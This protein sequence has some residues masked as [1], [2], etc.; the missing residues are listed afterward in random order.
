MLRSSRPLGLALGAGLLLGSLAIPGSAHADDPTTGTT[1]TAAQV[2]ADLK[3]VVAASADATAKGYS[4]HIDDAAKH[5]RRFRADVTYDAVHGRGLIEENGTYARLLIQHRGVYQPIGRSRLG[6]RWGRKAAE[7]INRPRAIWLFKPDSTTDL[8][9]GHP[10]LTQ[11]AP[12]AT[13]ASIVRG[14]YFT[15]RDGATQS[16]ADDGVTTYTVEATESVSDTQTPSSETFTI[17]VAADGTLSAVTE[18]D[19]SGNYAVTYG[20]GLQHVDVPAARTVLT[21]H[22]IVVGYVLA[23]MPIE[24]RG[25]ASN[26][27][28]LVGHDPITGASRRIDLGEL[29][30][31]V[32]HEVQGADHRNPA[33]R[34]YSTRNVARGIAITGTNRY[35]HEKFVITIVLRHGQATIHRS[36]PASG[37]EIGGIANGRSAGLANGYDSLKRWEIP[38]VPSI[39]LLLSRR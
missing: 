6:P 21:W 14:R 15:L 11:V 31:D 13:L 23:V 10:I 25:M 1:L 20:Y 12:G 35:R 19:Q 39:P 26:V 27:V 18:D 38:P 24:L 34:I 36:Y 5:E 3:L 37:R 28:N 4:A 22:Q 17:T 30:A 32:R 16:V 2:K 33:G 9:H 7:A 8:T 29:R